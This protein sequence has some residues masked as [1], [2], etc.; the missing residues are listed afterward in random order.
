M[1]SLAGDGFTARLDP[2]PRVA[3]P[4]RRDRGLRVGVEVARTAAT[5]Q[6]RLR[7]RVRFPGW[8]L[9]GAAA[10]VGARQPG[11]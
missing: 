4:A 2:T 7:S 9:R 8:R 5:A 11:G 6:M 1:R 10:G 3:E